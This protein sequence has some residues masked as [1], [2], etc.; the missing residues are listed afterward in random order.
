M[1]TLSDLTV[2]GP[3][4]PRF[5]A[6]FTGWDDLS[7]TDKLSIFEYS[8]TQGQVIYSSDFKNNSR[9]QTLDKLSLTMTNISGGYF[10]DTSKIT[11]T[12][13]LVSNGVLQI[14]DR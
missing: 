3:N 5:G 13:Y 12:D 2:W 6:S 14:L 7:D 9:F 8:I 1:N 4:D 10:V 11:T